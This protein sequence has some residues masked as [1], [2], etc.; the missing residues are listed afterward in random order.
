[1]NRLQEPDVRILCRS[2]W[3]M[4]ASLLDCQWKLFADQFQTGLK[5]MD[6]VY[7]KRANPDVYFGEQR[8]TMSQNV[9]RFQVLERQAAERIRQGLAPPKEIY[10]TPYRE[11]IDWSKFPEWAKPGDPEVFEGA[12]EG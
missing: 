3:Q 11:R 4:L 2:W 12:H 7:C 8:E 5:V 1:M 9:N 10:E 6:R